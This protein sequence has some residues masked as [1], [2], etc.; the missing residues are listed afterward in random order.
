MTKHTTTLKAFHSAKI[1]YPTIR[2]VGSIVL[3]TLYKLIDV[4]FNEDINHNLPIK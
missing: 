4:Y 3:H 2:A 1:Y